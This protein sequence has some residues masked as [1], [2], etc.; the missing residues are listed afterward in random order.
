MH[1]MKPDNTTIPEHNITKPAIHSTTGRGNT[2]N[3]TAIVFTVRRR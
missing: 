2:E 3:R 1:P